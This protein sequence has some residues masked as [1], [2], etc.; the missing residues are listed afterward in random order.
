MD[1]R[2]FVTPAPLDRYDLSNK[3]AVV[4]DVLRCTT[5]VCAALHSGAR[6]VI[7]VAGQDE[8]VEMRNKLGAD[9]AVLAGEREGHMIENFDL[10]NSPL[11]FTPETVDK[12]VV[13]TTTTNGTA[14]FVRARR[15]ALVISCAMVN[16]SVVAGRVIR[17][18]RDLV[19]VCSGNEGGFSI[20]DTLCAGLLVDQLT[21]R[22]GVKA[23]L[24]DA[25]SLALLLYR[26]SRT[27]IGQSIAQGEHGRYLRSIGFTDDVAM[28][29]QIDEI[30]VLP[31]LNDGRLVLEES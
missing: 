22:Y 1:V 30:P 28:A 14:A 23:E 5:S 31:V 6:G 17:E 20:E 25:G 10:G 27:S 8:A 2:L 15:A 12:K 13:V 21:S 24:N 19:V 11:E 29:A 3:T 16:V 26:S 4:I 9:L 7:P 18:D